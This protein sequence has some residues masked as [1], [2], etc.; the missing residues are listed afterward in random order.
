MMIMMIFFN[1]G[2]RRSLLE[3]PEGHKNVLS[4]GTRYKNK[5]AKLRKEKAFSKYNLIIKNLRK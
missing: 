4:S 1:V 2:G 3:P 5:E